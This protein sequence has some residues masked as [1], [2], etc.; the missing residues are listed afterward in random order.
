MKGPPVGSDQPA[1]A[2]HP[3]V[4]PHVLSEIGQRAQGDIVGNASASVILPDRV[5]RREEHPDV[6]IPARRA[7]ARRQQRPPAKSLVAAHVLYHY[8][9][10]PLNNPPKHRAA[11]RGRF[12]ATYFRAHV[13]R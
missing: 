3:F 12:C 7:K 11:V 8:G 5:E 9:T 6:T 2:V 4:D 1:L 13:T 10:T